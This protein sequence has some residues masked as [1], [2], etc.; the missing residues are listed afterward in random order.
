[1][2][3]REDDNKRDKEPQY[4]IQLE[5]NSDVFEAYNRINRRKRDDPKNTMRGRSTDRESKDDKTQK[6]DGEKRVYSLGDWKRK[7]AS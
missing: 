6:R 7:Q 3:E 1:M 2:A 5:S 4:P